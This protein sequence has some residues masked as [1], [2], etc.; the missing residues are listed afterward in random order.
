MKYLLYLKVICR[1][2]RW[3]AVLHSGDIILAFVILLLVLNLHF[4]AD[5]LVELIGKESSVLLLSIIMLGQFFQSIQAAKKAARSDKKTFYK[6]IGFSNADFFLLVLHSS[7]MSNIASSFLFWLTMDRFFLKIGIW[8]VVLYSGFQIAIVFTT[9]FLMTKANG[10]A[11]KSKMLIR[12]SSRLFSKKTLAFA[13]KDF[14]EL[15]WRPHLMLDH[16]FIA[17]CIFLFILIRMDYLVSVYLICTLNTLVCYDSYE[18]DREHMSLFLLLHI[19]NC[20]LFRF[21]LIISVVL[22]LIELVIHTIIYL[23]LVG[24]FSIWILAILP[25]L[26]LNAYMQ[27]VSLGIICSSR[28]PS[29]DFSTGDFLGWWTISVIPVLSLVLFGYAISRHLKGN[30]RIAGHASIKRD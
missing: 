25:V 13:M 21:R 17:V 1:T 5:T 24:S 20:Q 30:Q 26:L 23:M 16:I 18:A 27:H 3:R 28:F 9:L 19:S 4:W 2:D 15:F 6:I 8:V 14:S 7:L 12:N 10:R 22:N 11:H 29:S